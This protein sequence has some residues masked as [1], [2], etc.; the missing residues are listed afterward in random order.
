MPPRIHVHVS[1]HTLFKL[2][3][4]SMK[5]NFILIIFLPFCFKLLIVNNIINDKEGKHKIEP[6]FT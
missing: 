6:Q 3:Y 4:G 1:Q 2:F 5:F